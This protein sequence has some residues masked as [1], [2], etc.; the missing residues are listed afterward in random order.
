M[1]KY[2]PFTVTN[3]LNRLTERAEQC[4]GGLPYVQGYLQSLF[5][6]MNLDKYQLDIM[7]QNIKHLDEIIKLDNETQ[8]T[9]NN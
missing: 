5:K 4:E 3:F 9:V 7:E 6:E 8:V 2:H 1:K